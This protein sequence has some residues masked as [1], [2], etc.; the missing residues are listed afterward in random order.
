MASSVER[1]LSRLEGAREMADNRQEQWRDLFQL[2]N[3]RKNVDV[4]PGTFIKLLPAGV[5][6]Q[7][8]T[9]DYARNCCNEICERSGETYRDRGR[10]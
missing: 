6:S 2:Q 4:R 8:S 9:W 3:A 7:F 1:R 10:E 5:L